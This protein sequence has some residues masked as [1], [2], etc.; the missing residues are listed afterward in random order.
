MRGD[1]LRRLGREAWDRAE[2]QRAV[3]LTRNARE[4]ALLLERAGACRAQFRLPGRRLPAACAGHEAAAGLDFA[5]MERIVLYYFV[6][7]A[8]FVMVVGG[9]WLLWR[10]KIYLDQESKQPISVETPLGKFTSNYP[11][12]AL[13]A[14]GFVPLIYPIVSINQLSDY[15]KVESVRIHGL[16]HSTADR[17]FVYATR[18][19]DVP[20]RSGDFKLVVPYF[21]NDQN[22]YKVLLIVGD[23]VLDQV[24]ASRTDKQKEIEVKFRPPPP[25]VESAIT[26]DYASAVPPVP[27]EFQ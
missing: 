14:L 4:R 25:P 6:A 5:C 19:N 17:V 10:E 15:V 16:A 21:E 20:S 9:M 26:A 8:G 18:A 22:D 7:L 1:L 12:L 2:F 23:R 13:F 11:A 27:P 24:H 3:R